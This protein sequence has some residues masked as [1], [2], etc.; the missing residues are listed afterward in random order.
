RPPS[1]TLATPTAITYPSSLALPLTRLCQLFGLHLMMTNDLAEFIE[2]G[3]INP[4][5]QHTMWIRQAVQTLL[6]QLRP[7]AIALADAW[8]LP[9]YHLRTALGQFSAD[10]YALLMESARQEPLN[11]MPPVAGQYDQVVKPIM[12]FQKWLDDGD[13]EN[14]NRHP[15]TRMP[16]R[17]EEGVAGQ[18]KLLAKL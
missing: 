3:L 12:N 5:Q 15:V 9:D 18:K 4:R 8:S 6:E 14:L 2:A 1:G 17:K 13:Y 16:A 10:P 11:H 7:D